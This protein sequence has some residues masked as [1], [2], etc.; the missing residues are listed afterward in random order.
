MVQ[1][2]AVPEV[3]VADLVSGSF[4]TG[5]HL[6]MAER[7]LANQEEGGL[8]V[9]TLENLEN[10]GRERGVWAII[11]GKGHQGVIDP[12]PISDVGREPLEYAQDTERLYPEHQEP[13]PEES[14]GR[15][16][17]RRHLPTCPPHRPLKNYPSSEGK[18]KMTGQPRKH[19]HHPGQ[20]SA[21]LGVMFPGAY[22]T[23]TEGG[24][25]MRT[26]TATRWLILIVLIWHM[27]SG[28][29]LSLAQDVSLE[30]RTKDG[31]TEY[32]MGEPIAL[33]M[34]F[35]SSN[36][37]YIVDT[38][39]RYPPLQGSQDDFVVNPKEGSSD[40]LEDYRRALSRNTWFDT[41]GLRGIGR[42]G[43][44][45]VV[46]DLYLNDYVRFSKPGHYVLTLGDRR[47][48]IARRSWN[49]SSQVIELISK[50]LSLTILASNAEWQQQQLDS[51]LEALK[52]RPGV[53]VNACR[54]LSSLGTAEAE[55]AMVDSLEDGYETMGCGFSYVLLGVTH[56]RLVLDRMQQKL[57][58]PQASIS[59]QFVET[60]A[61]LKI[62][63]ERRE[64]DFY[65]GQSE[66]RKEINNA[67]FSLLPEKKG[68]ARTAAISTLVNESLLNSGTEDAA[69]N[70]QVLQL[71]AE[72]FDQMSSQAQSTLL[73]ARWADI[74]GPA[75]VPVLRRCAEADSTASCGT[76]QDELLLT[77]LNELSPAD[78]R[79][80]ILADIQKENPR[81]P[82]HVLAL[83]PD[84]ELPELDG[85]LREHLQSKNQNL[86]T[87]AGLIQ[88]YASS[89]IGPAVVSF[90]DE[91]GLGN[92]GGQV[93]PNLIAYLLRVQPDAGE[94]ELRA[95]LATRNGTGWYKYLLRDVAQRFPS[96]KIQGTAIDA[97]SDPGPEVVQSA[98]QALALMGDNQAKAALFESLS[99]WRA[100]WL[101]REHEMLWMPGDGPIADDRNVGDEMIR[102]IATGAGWL[103]SEEDQRRLLQSVLTENQKQQAKQFVD[104]ARNRP[105]SITI[106]NSGFPNVQIIIA[107][108]NYESIEPAKRKLAQFPAGTSFL[109][110]NIPPVS[111]ETQ[112]AV[113]E[114]TSFLTQHGMRLEIRPV[115][116]P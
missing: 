63:D 99:A 77:R 24:C 97:L 70:A 9:V 47:V 107:Q 31:R 56:R 92:L 67:L 66:A 65:K 87:T 61:A 72:V 23:T 59:P 33:Q 2:R 42:L 74:A 35:A 20:I 91:H 5:S 52:H 1:S 78:A 93:E 11:E 53:N 25:S 113:T 8:G 73:S 44:E 6:R 83:L 48:S 12:N 88:R 104:T 49:E 50:P 108:Y 95:A 27:S 96:S 10:L 37:Q 17:N 40:P 55:L 36:K 29:K 51:A 64:V 85:V 94:Q 82:S 28:A 103:L 57:E 69:R 102:A 13:H 111:A 30:V 22:T 110:Q 89:A 62:L 115:A 116:G 34:V 54:T 16:E 60:M 3:V 76:L 21:E 105:V 18:H 114:I 45:P 46:L 14:H 19:T 98:V 80:V 86:D 4:D 71:A 32:H 39:F 43:K 38:S 101:G 106:I 100:R 109:L 58:S 26:K 84:K 81:F 75:M 79:E 7:P 90:L 41:G 112:R 15:H 68:P